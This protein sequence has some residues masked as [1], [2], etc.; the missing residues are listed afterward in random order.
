MIT[1]INKSNSSQSSYLDLIFLYSV[2]CM[3][4]KNKKLKEFISLKKN[5]NYWFLSDAS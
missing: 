3:K 1:F 4:Y 2:C 5:K